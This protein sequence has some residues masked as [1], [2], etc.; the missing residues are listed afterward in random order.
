[1]HCI[2][3]ERFIHRFP[4]SPRSFA[5]VSISWPIARRSLPAIL[6]RRNGA[7]PRKGVSAVITSAGGKVIRSFRGT[8]FRA[9]ERT[10]PVD[11][12]HLTI[13]MPVSKAAHLGHDGSASHRQRT[14][15][16]PKTDDKWLTRPDEK[17]L[18][19]F[20]ISGS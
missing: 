5:S 19:K 2:A 6:A 11:R 20:L 16:L 13:I 17:R 7:R 15:V 3:N 18:L 12:T 9:R 14:K 10:A 1:M 4:S 8:C